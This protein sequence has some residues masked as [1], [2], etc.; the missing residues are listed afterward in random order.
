MSKSIPELAYLMT[1]VERKYGRRIS[2]A[3]DFESLSVVIELQTGSR[4]SSST[5]KRLW[6]YV[7][8]AP[9]PRISTLDVL[10]E[11]IGEKDFKSFCKMLKDTRS[12]NSAFFTAKCL[13]ISDLNVGQKVEIGW[14]PDRLAVLEYLGNHRMRVLSA[15]NSKLRPGDEFEANHI[16]LEY[17]LYISRIY[18]DGEET[19]PYVAGLQGGILSVKVEK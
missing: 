1:E 9:T 2:T 15:E 19:P 3:T 14:A 4:I 7:S 16:M 17:P 18:R 10:C 12:F 13:D 6:G 8:M 5:L 11:F